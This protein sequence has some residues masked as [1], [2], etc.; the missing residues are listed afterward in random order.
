MKILVGILHCIENEFPE[1]LAA[2]KGQTHRDFD[3]FVLENLPNKAAHE[4]LY[5]RFMESAARYELFVKLDADMVLCRSDML[6]RIAERFAAAPQMD[7]LCIGVHDFFTARM[8]DSLNVFRSTVTW[9]RDSERIFPDRSQVAGQV[10]YD[11]DTLAPAANHCPNPSRFQAFHFGVHKAVKVM[12][13]GVR[14]KRTHAS[15]EHWSNLEHLWANYESSRDLRLGMALL[16]A[17][18]AL[19][20]KCDERVLDYASPA[21]RALFSPYE[22]ADPGQVDRAL[23]A[24]SLRAFSFLPLASRGKVLSRFVSPRL[25]HPA[26]AG[27][28]KALAREC[29]RGRGAGQN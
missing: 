13:I 16:G 23:R 8:I 19:R 11:H 12:Q 9:Q 14:E 4:A 27:A 6:A 5:A 21:L 20:G 24:N 29:L 25:W 7:M 26:N 15:R 1:C 17:E 10:V 18:L 2:L 22:S 28:W 3:F